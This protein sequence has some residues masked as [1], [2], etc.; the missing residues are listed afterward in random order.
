M[1]SYI[2]YDIAE[3]DSQRNQIALGVSVGDNI[4]VEC[5]KIYDAKKLMNYLFGIRQ[6]KPKDQ[7]CIAA[8]KKASYEYYEVTSWW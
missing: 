2:L 6:D 8:A 3:S 4:P 7:G 1:H 5:D